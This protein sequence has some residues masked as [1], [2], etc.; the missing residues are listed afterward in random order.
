MNDSAGTYN[1]KPPAVTDLEYESESDVESD[2]N[3]DP[4]MTTVDKDGP[5]IAKD[6]DI[7]VDKKVK[8]GCTVSN[9]IRPNGFQP[10]GTASSRARTN[11]GTSNYKETTSGLSN[12]NHMTTAAR[13]C[14]SDSS[15]KE[16][17]ET[18]KMTL[19]ELV[20]SGDE[21]MPAS[22]SGQEYRKGRTNHWSH[23]TNDISE[24]MRLNVLQSSDS[25]VRED[26]WKKIVTKEADSYSCGERKDII[27]ADD[28][29]ASDLVGHEELWK[30]IV[31]KEADTYSCGERKEIIDADNSIAEEK[32]EFRPGRKPK[33]A[34]EGDLIR[35]MYKDYDNNSVSWVQGRLVSRIDKL[36][37]AVKSEWTMNRFRVDT[38]S[39]IAHWGGPGI[40]PS[41]TTVNIS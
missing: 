2:A 24:K 19:P 36:D 16:G 37:D 20:E 21:T 30:K 12:K 39:T 28:S 29:T 7:L 11:H 9:R 3:D 41:S 15:M 1:L 33:E 27:D 25:I 22:E 26:L 23:E 32:I 5:R 34:I 13:E 8:V 10:V 18:H 35:L 6:P 40:P 31:T 17:I 38:I 14:T 4:L